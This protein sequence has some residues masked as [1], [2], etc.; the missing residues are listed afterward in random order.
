MNEHQLSMGKLHETSTSERNNRK[1]ELCEAH[2]RFCESRNDSYFH[3]NVLFLP[4]L[5]QMDYLRLL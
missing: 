1:N 3:R 4:L 5:V 2:L